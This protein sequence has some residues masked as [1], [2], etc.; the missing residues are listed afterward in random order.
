MA[1]LQSDV[2][3]A[4]HPSPMYRY[5]AAVFAEPSLTVRGCCGAVQ[6]VQ[7]IRKNIKKMINLE[8]LAA[9]TNKRRLIQQVSSDA[10]VAAAPR[11]SPP[12][13][14]PLL[15]HLA[16]DPTPPL[17]G[18]C[19]G[20]LAYHNVACCGCAC[21]RACRRCTRSWPRC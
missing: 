12:P 10:L 7:K 3:G 6:I 19:A 2:N 14:L 1:L 9:G 17:G 21:V 15:I 8:E 11:P 18:V 5:P 4:L 20:T 16:R 13:Q